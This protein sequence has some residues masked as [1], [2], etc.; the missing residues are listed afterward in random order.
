MNRW[1]RR[2]S[3]DLLRQGVASLVQAVV[4]SQ[5]AIAEI[6]DQLARGDQVDFARYAAAGR[7]GMAAATDIAN[8]LK[9]TID[10][11]EKS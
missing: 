4:D 10:T 2:A 9:R 7:S 1:A 11:L 3:A 6:S 5:H 8:T